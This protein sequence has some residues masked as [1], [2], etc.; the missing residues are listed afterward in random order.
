MN[1]KFVKSNLRILLMLI[2][3]LILFESARADNFIN[4][5]NIGHGQSDDGGGSIS[6]QQGVN[7]TV[8]VDNLVFY[9]YTKFNGANPNSCQLYDGVTGLMIDNGTFVG[10]EC[11]LTRNVTTIKNRYYY[12]YSGNDDFTTYTQRYKGIFASYPITNNYINITA[13][14]YATNFSL[15]FTNTLNINNWV[16]IGTQILNATPIIYSNTTGL[17]NSTHYEI[18]TIKNQWNYTGDVDLYSVDLTS[19]NISTGT[20]GYFQ[21]ENISLPIYAKNYT[22]G[23]TYKGNTSLNISVDSTKNNNDSF[24]LLETR[25]DYVC[26]QESVNVSTTCGGLDTGNYKATTSTTFEQPASN[27]FDGDWDTTCYS[28]GSPSTTN[29]TM[30]YTIPTSVISA[31]WTVKYGDTFLPATPYNETYIIPQDCFLANSII[32]NIVMI[33]PLGD[34]TNASGYCFNTTNNYKTIF[35]RVTIADSAGRLFYE[36]AVTWNI[37][38]IIQSQQNLTFNLSNNIALNNVLYYYLTLNNPSSI[39]YNMTVDFTPQ[40]GNVFLYAEK[41]PINASIIYNATLNNNGIGNNYSFTN[42]NLSS[43][44]N[45][46]WGNYNLTYK[47]FNM[48]SN[49]TYINVTINSS[50]KYLPSCLFHD[51]I[52]NITVNDSNDGVVNNFTAILNY[53]NGFTQTV[54]TTTGVA[55]INLSMQNYTV[56]I[57][58]EG[59]IIDT[60]TVNVDSSFVRYNFFVV[61]TNS[62]NITIYDEDTGSPIYYNSTVLF[63]SINTSQTYSYVI[64]HSRYM[65]NFLPETYLVT[66]T[67]PFYSIRTY[68][69]TIANRSTQSL[70]VYL[71]Q[72][73]SSVLFTVI[74]KYTGKALENCVMSMYKNINSTLT[75]IEGKYTDITGKAEFNFNSNTFYQFTTICDGYTTKTFNL[76][77]ILFTTYNVEMESTTSVHESYNDVYIEDT[78]KQ[79]TDNAVQD[80]TFK[81]TSPMGLLTFYYYNITSPCGESKSFSGNNLAGD[82]STNILNLSMCTVGFND[83]VIMFYNYTISNGVTVS[84]GQE[85]TIFGTAISNYTMTS[86]AQGTFGMGILERW[87]VVI[88]VAL[89]IGGVATMVG[90]YTIGILLVLLIF[91]FFSFV[92]DFINPILASLVMLFCLAMLFV[93]LRGE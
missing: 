17:I 82:V 56:S 68:T 27:C 34:N 86:S 60:K 19:F 31:N 28:T 90:G 41:Y 59:F 11:K 71:T 32:L 9:N 51:A 58:P 39:I 37:N 4:L 92:K 20:S 45:V 61:T 1:L 84:G 26:Y 52:L 47:A 33:K 46:D 74:N 23:I 48:Y 63:T 24:S 70:N 72:S 78:P 55:S 36:D 18:G 57:N 80:Y 87:I 40:T 77:P 3:I 13:Q 5:T 8:L 79:F 53:T 73:N 38:N 62:L 67:T 2:I 43:T 75:L 81:I 69:I 30:N 89:V 83:R 64:N 10:N 15:K 12:F 7:V 35:S 65:D 6:L 88:L 25:A 54:S 14:S 29:L 16:A 42:L 93:K 91:G 21:S 49:C 44:Q 85:Y 22:V 66:F 76:Y 50:D